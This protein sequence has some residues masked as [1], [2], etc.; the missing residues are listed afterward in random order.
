MPSLQR[1]PEADCAGDDDQKLST[2]GIEK[3]AHN[4]GYWIIDADWSVVLLVTSGNE[5]GPFIACKES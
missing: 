3:I 4:V 2:H 5:L 1:M